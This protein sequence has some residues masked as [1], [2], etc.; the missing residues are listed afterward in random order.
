MDC[1]VKNDYT[2]KNDEN[3][4]DDLHGQIKRSLLFKS[5]N[6]LEGGGFLF[7]NSFNL[8]DIKIYASA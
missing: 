5:Q 4:N 3:L 1:L 2:N 7:D 6:L 8:R